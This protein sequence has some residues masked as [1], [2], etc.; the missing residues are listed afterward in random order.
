M[1][2][3]TFIPE[4]W[5]ARLLE[6]YRKNL[7]Y[8]NL[9]NRNYEGDISEYGDTVHINSL[10]DVTVKTYSKGT[11]IDDPEELTTSDQTLLIDQGD[12]FNM[13]I[14]DVDKVQ[15]RSDLMD[16]AMTS[17][18]YGLSDKADKY[19]AG[20]LKA[21]TAASAMT[22]IVGNDSTPVVVTKDNAY[23]I[24]VNM[25]TALDKANVPSQGRWIVMP[26][27]YEGFMLLDPRFA[28]NTSESNTRLVNGMVARAAGFDIY[29][30]NNVPNTTQTKYK[31][32]ASTNACGTYAEQILKT[33]AY[34]REKGFDDGVKGLHV[35]GAKIL[36]PE[37]VA[38]ATVN[39]TAGG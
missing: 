3:A 22:S 28:Y 34:R 11:D 38:V 32:I 16:A 35:Y 31:V 37:I 36:R 23:E 29:I 20:L 17:A 18:S 27:E 12:Y 9:L 14:N 6:A 4:V 24:M 13:K 2:I 15:A 5:A 30:S 7:V 25:K 19:L 26:P 1:S 8:A 21:G 33:E 10:T 39:F